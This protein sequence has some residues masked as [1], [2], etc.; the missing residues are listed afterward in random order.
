MRR[1]LSLLI[2]FSVSAAGHSAVADDSMTWPGSAK[3]AVSLS[4]DDALDSQLDNAIPALNRHDIK[5]SFYLT[6]ASPPIRER[7]AEWRAAAS[8]GHEL[9]NHTIYHACSGSLPGREWV[10]PHNDLDTRSLAEMEAEVVMANTIL[11][12]IDG[13]DERTFTPPCADEL[14]GGQNYVDAVASL[15]VG[16]K[17]RDEGAAAQLGPRRFAREALHGL[18]HYDWPGNVRELSHVIERAVTLSEGEWIEAEDF[19][20]AEGSRLA[21][22]VTPSSTV[23]G[24][25]DALNLDATTQRLVVAALAKTHGHKGQAAALLGVHPRTLTRMMRRYAL[26]EE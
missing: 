18:E 26:P 15:F 11:H 22:D 1:T 12:A 10:L 13:R 4:Y 19:G 17:S 6:L 8:D 25:R 2:V 20:W 5:A 7:L 3:V 23:P 24:S 9:G 16:I 14:A 21:A